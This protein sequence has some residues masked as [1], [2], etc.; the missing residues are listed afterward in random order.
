V[1]Q[2]EIINKD[3]PFIDLPQKSPIAAGR[4]QGDAQIKR[5]HVDLWGRSWAAGEAQRR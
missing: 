5:P 1:V 2:S 4:D 3:A